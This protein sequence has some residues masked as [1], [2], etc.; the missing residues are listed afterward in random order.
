MP[1]RDSNGTTY[2]PAVT[3]RTRVPIEFGKFDNEQQSGG[4]SGPSLVPQ[5]LNLLSF[6]PSSMRSNGSIKIDPTSPDNTNLHKSINHEEIHSLL[7]DLS[8]SG[9]LDHLQ[10]ANPLYKAIASKL[11]GRG[12]DPIQEVPAYMGAFEPAQ[13]PGVEQSQRD[14]Y[15]NY[16]A[17]QLF[18]LDPKLASKYRSLAEVPNVQHR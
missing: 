16:L 4:F 17:N 5:I 11:T 13:N 2:G 8:F 15:V 9:S 14:S 3:R 7:Q 6:L 10:S 18:K 1:V 12:G